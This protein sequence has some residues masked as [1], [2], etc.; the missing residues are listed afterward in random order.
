M[1]PGRQ[2]NRVIL[3]EVVAGSSAVGGAELSSRGA[4]SG[5]EEH[6]Q[7]GAESAALEM[8]T[9]V[10]SQQGEERKLR[11][12]EFDLLLGVLNRCAH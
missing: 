10:L 5:T 7:S 3:S 1:H 6:G 4:K 12:G 2:R 9:M 8:A 11:G